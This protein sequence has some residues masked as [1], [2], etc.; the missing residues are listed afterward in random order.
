MP[1][2]MRRGEPSPSGQQSRRPARSCCQGVDLLGHALATLPR[3]PGRKAYALD[4]LPRWRCWRATDA[5]AGCNGSVLT[6]AAL[7][8]GQLKSSARPAGAAVGSPLMSARIANGS[9]GG[10]RAGGRAPPRSSSAAP[11]DVEAVSG[12]TGPIRGRA[13][14]PP[15]LAP[16]G[17]GSMLE[18]S[19]TGMARLASLR[20][21]SRST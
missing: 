21:I 14:G 15:G 20:S 19:A 18:G 2:A 13:A 11:P 1:F 5:T 6:E 12:T 3:W 17:A 7:S 9:A 4:A 10:G 8:R 16:A